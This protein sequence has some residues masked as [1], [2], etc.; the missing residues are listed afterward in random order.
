MALIRPVVLVFQE[1]ATPTVEITTPDLNELV[2][3]PAYY[4]QDY[5]KPGTTT[6]ADKAQI[7]LAVDYGQLEAAPTV[8][9]PVGAGVIVVADPP[10]NV[11]GALLDPASA[12]LWLDNV[13]VKITGGAAGTTSAS[14]PNQFDQTDSVDFTTGATKVL[15]GDRIV[16]TDASAATIVRTVYTVDSA[17]RLHFTQ[18]IP[19]SGFTPAG[20]QTWR[21]E[22]T[23]NDQLVE[24]GAGTYLT[25]S[26]NQ[27]LIN[28]GITVSVASQGAKVVQY[29]KVYVAY[30]TLRQD[31]Q[32]LDTVKSKDEILAKVGRLDVRNP[33]GVGC[34][35]TLQNTTTQVQFFGVASDD[36]AGHVGARDA[37]ASRPDV[38]A[39]TP[40]TT[41]VSIIAMW[42]VDNLGLALPD[43][44][45][46]RPQRFRVVL[47]S[48]TLPVTSTL[49]EPSATGQPAAVT[50]SAPS[51][52]IVTKGTFPGLDFVVGGVIPGDKL[53]VTL[54][55]AGTI[56]N[57]TYLIAA[58]LSA[59]ALEVDPSTP[60]P[61]AETGNLSAKVTDSTGVT[62]KIAVTAV[63]AAITAI[64]GDLY[65]QLIDPN[66]Q[67]VS[68]GLFAGDLL[69]MPADPTTTNF[70]GTNTQWV[71]ASV[72][73]ENRL[74]IK[75]NGA[76]T[77]TVEN[78]LPHGVKRVGGA[79]VPTT[80]TLNYRVQRKLTKDQ[81]VTALVAVAQSFSSRR[82]VLVWP[83]KCDVAGVVGGT[84][85]PGYYLSCAVG[86]M[87]AGLPAHQGFTFLGIAGVSQ[88][89]D[90]NTYFN[91]TQLTQISEG[92]W[93]VFA[94]QTPQSL[95]YSI[96]QL[97]T[98]VTTL[99]TGE[100][101][102]VK[103]F[104][105]VSMF[106]VDIL[107]QF[108]GVYNVNQ[109]T[110][111]LIRAALNTGGET[112]LLRTYAKIGAPLTKFSLI[113][114]GVSPLSAD[115]VVSHLAIGLPTPLNV[116]E[117]HLV[118]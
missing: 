117:L 17:T 10:N 53:V 13:H 99:Q 95:P 29:A 65:L 28:G 67:F 108:L 83:D 25:I 97:T 32:L 52:T 62:T 12:Q 102:V 35:V 77:A 3:G 76:D 91:D 48:G 34:F 4:I 106:F 36:L 70:S 37:L 43:E 22:R 86:G 93:F 6:P 111:T 114:L 66:G 56:R 21:V 79:L 31:L 24:T 118:A 92:G 112:L 55:A 82:C 33:L 60:F 7:R 45:L 109:D 110:L 94:Q 90:S 58:V 11:V 9:P 39:I 50:G 98:D 44:V 78:E 80:A 5:F 105:F 8:T 101:S 74:V 88:I 103:N 2:V 41:D 51:P 40:L 18:D 26:G 71:I 49:I 63:T 113:D 19:A 69:Q 46:G 20:S 87:T 59:T 85:Q 89:Y 61:A 23:L 54:D 1:F 38:Y 104:D 73:S 100:Y 68:A 72:L 14:T 84:K 81:Q 15:P 75:N 16:I 42:N 47:G 30:R 64:K 116:F 57:G 27:L 115:R 96:H 107:E